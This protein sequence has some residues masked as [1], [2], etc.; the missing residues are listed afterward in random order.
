[1]SFK[2]T[3]AGAVG[4]I[5]TKLAEAVAKEFLNCYSN[6]FLLKQNWNKS[7]SWLEGGKPPLNSLRLSMH[8]PSAGSEF[9][10]CMSTVC[11]RAGTR[12]VT[13]DLQHYKQE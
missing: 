4:N 8:G 13:F 3:S 9:P 2:L 6:C 12:N 10:S 1:M 7:M 5:H 11:C